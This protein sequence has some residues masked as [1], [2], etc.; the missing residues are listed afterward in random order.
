M[1]SI[2]LVNDARTRAIA[3]IANETISEHEAYLLKWQ[4][5]LINEDS[6]EHALLRSILLADGDNFAR[7][8]RSFPLQTHAIR[9]WR[10]TWIGDVL[11]NKGLLD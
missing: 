10:E 3:A 2:A 8:E 11:R 9:L 1:E 7:L 4:W 5:G 6:F